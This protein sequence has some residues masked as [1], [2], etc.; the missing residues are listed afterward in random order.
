M[1]KLGLK[2]F[3][4]PIRDPKESEWSDSMFDAEMDEEEAELSGEEG[5]YDHR[6]FRLN[7][8]GKPTSDDFVLK[9]DYE[10]SDW[11]VKKNGEH[12]S[13]LLMALTNLCGQLP[14]LPNVSNDSSARN[15]LW[16]SKGKPFF[17]ILLMATTDIKGKPKKR[18]KTPVTRVGKR[19]GTI[20][21]DGEMMCDDFD[22]F[23]GMV[24]VH[25]NQT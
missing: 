6:R 18:S 17:E 19:F 4:R 8:E 14:V 7:K 15:R 5:W 9:Y 1:P 11:K 22:D 12:D 20:T 13:T 2:V 16:V 23:G 10:Y 24:S 3:V 25:N 21:T